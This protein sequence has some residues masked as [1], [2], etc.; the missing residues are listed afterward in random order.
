MSC[1]IMQAAQ[2]ILVSPLLLAIVV[3]FLACILYV[4]F[5]AWH[6]SYT[7]A[8]LY[9]TAID[10]LGK[11]VVI[12]DAQQ[13]VKHVNQTWC[14]I[15][16]YTRDESVGR[17]GGTKFLQGAGTDADAIDAMRQAVRTGKSYSGT[18][19][20]YKK[21]GTPFWNEVTIRAVRIDSHI[22][23]FVGTIDDVTEKIELEAAK[24]AR[25]EGMIFRMY[26]ALG[27]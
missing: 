1:E 17:Q 23:E 7:A 18:V 6:S 21:D 14:T 19:R 25:M 27:N 24:H 22:E 16:G 9:A 13:N 2:Q 26:P 5:K 11:G 4:A 8:H 15:T 3:A 10:V 12:T 20:N